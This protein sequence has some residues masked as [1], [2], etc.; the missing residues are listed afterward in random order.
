MPL[1]AQQLIETKVLGIGS[2]LSL[3]RFCM[4]SKLSTGEGHYS[5]LKRGQAWKL[6]NN[7]ASQRYIG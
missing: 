5:T 3:P 6:I 2:R 4:L 1:C 7:S